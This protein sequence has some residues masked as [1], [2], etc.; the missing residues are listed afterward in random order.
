MTT[1]SILTVTWI[2]PMASSGHRTHSSGRPHASATSG[3]KLLVPTQDIGLHS[4]ELRASRCAGENTRVAAIAAPCTPPC[5][6]ILPNLLVLYHPLQAR[7]P[8][9][10]LAARQIHC[11]RMLSIFTILKHPGTSRIGRT[12]LVEVPLRSGIFVITRAR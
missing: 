11:R 9:K 10:S 2:P 5:N 6:G 7:N 1:K 4:P 12:W 3:E 8:W